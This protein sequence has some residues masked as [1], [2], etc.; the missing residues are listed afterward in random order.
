M[1]EACLH[2]LCQN[3]LDS[4][5]SRACSSMLRKMVVRPFEWF[6]QEEVARIISSTTANVLAVAGK[7]PFPKSLTSVV[8]G[9]LR[10]MS[11]YRAG[12][13]VGTARHS[14]SSSTPPSF[15]SF[16]AFAF[17]FERSHKLRRPR[18]LQFYQWP[19]RQYSTRRDPRLRCLAATR[20]KAPWFSNFLR[21]RK[22]LLLWTGALLLRGLRLVLCLLQPRRETV[23]RRKRR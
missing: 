13:G 23:A 8:A 15:S 7:R 18:L 17:A 1:A 6:M 19:C 4:A 3:N 10:H 22:S 14:V 12:H 2:A 9:R 16:L 11:R 20:E 5:W 21:I